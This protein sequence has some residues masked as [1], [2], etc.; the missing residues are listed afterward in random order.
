MN[1]SKVLRF[2]PKLPTR[3]LIT[4][5]AGDSENITEKVINALSDVS[6]ENLELKV[7]VGPANVNLESL[8]EAISRSKREIEIIENPDSM[9]IL[10]AWADVAISGSGST[11]YELAYLG[12]PSLVLVVADNQE[13]VGSALAEKGAAI[14]L[15]VVNGFD[16][17][18]FSKQLSALIGR[19]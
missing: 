11:C 2:D 5:G 13:N 15:N 9:S 16:R 18:I 8:R 19:Y 10:M 12:I 1:S 3:V 6:I 14:C 4:I 17:K 7:V